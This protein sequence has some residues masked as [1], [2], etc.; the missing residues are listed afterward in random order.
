MSSYVI[1]I[2]III[3][4]SSASVPETVIILLS[5]TILSQTLGGGGY[6]YSPFQVERKVQIR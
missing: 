3:Q 5:Y 4:L 2:T 6:Y 1:M